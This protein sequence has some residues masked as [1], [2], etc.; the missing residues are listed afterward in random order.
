MANHLVRNMMFPPHIRLRFLHSSVPPSPTTPTSSSSFTVDFLVNSCGLS[1]E[2]AL[3]VSNKFQ[4]NHK[5]PQKP[6]S[7][8]QLLKSHHFSDTHVAQLIAKRP[9]VLNCRIHDNLKPKFE[10][11]VEIGFEGELLPHIILSNSEIIG[12]SLG[13]GIKP[14]VQ[15][16]RLFLDSD[17]K[18][19]MVVKRSPWLLGRNMKILLKRNV[20]VLMKEGVPAHVVD[21]LLIL[22]PRFIHLNP[23]LVWIERN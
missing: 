14:S 10:Y 5:T 19:L 2:S 21:K 8:L 16:L 20:D 7:V 23:G 12:K 4:L 9:Q 11:L 22:H 3:S 17:E 18:F 15:F 13:S 6:Q 1:L